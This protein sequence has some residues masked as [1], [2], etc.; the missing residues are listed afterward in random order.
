MYYILR[1]HPMPKRATKSVTI[2]AR[3]TPALNKKLEA[4]AKKANRTKSEA[5]QL[6]MDEHLDYEIWFAEAVRKGI[7]SARK[8]DLVSHDDVFAELRAKSLQ[9]RRAQRRRAA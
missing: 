7:E 4:Y 6:V 8:G 3:I 1:E 9:R 5:I 2:T